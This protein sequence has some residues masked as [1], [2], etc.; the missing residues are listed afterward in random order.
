MESY[1]LFNWL[2]YIAHAI[3]VVAVTL[4]GC[5]MGFYKGGF[6]F[7]DRPKNEFRFHPLFMSLSL[8]LIN[9][10]AILIYRGFRNQPKI[11]TKLVH[12]ILQF[13][14]FIIVLLGLKAVFDSH[15]L[16]KGPD[17]RPDP[18]V[19]LY[20][21]HSWIG[22]SAVTLF[23]LQFVG[24]FI[25]FFKP[26]A[27]MEIRKMVMPTHRLTGL[28]IFVISLCA[29]L[30]GVAEISA[31]SMKCWLDDKV[32]CLEMWI[33][34]LFGVLIV[35]FAAIVIYLVAHPAWIRQ[36]LPSEIAPQAAPIL[37]EEPMQESSH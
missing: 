31:W 26:G 8:L 20:S 22:L 27:P 13:I 5:W 12:G 30:M 4:V 37:P 32:I 14:A 34:N 7:Q 11:Y 36:P 18:V 33:A 23:G 15:N 25:V 1:K 3:G 17:G 19:N 24:G 35:A 21:L 6:G 29:A 16:N 10:E 2:Y 28:I 9:G